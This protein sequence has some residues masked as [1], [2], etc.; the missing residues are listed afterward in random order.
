LST[1]T[2]KHRAYYAANR[3]RIKSLRLDRERK[4]IA[5][6]KGKYSIQKRHADQRKIPWEFTFDTWWSWWQDTGR[7]D[8][9]G[10]GADAAVMCRHGD[11]GPYNP[12]N[13]YCGTH[14]SNAKESYSIRG[15]NKLGQ[16]Q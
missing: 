4:W 8:E 5:T 15:V 7:W 14:T 6:P 12:E 11:T 9:R 1:Y 10:I 13:C 16:F 3:E 2:E